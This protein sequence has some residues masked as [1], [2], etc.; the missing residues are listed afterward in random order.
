MTETERS[1]LMVLVCVGAAWRTSGALRNYFLCEMLGT[2]INESALSRVSYTSTL[3]SFLYVVAMLP[4]FLSFFRLSW[5]QSKDYRPLVWSAITSF[6]PFAFAWLLMNNHSSYSW[7]S[8]VEGF[9]YSTGAMALW[10]ET[11]FKFP[12]GLLSFLWLVL[13]FYSY[14]WALWWNVPLWQ[15]LNFSLPAWLVMGSFGWIA[16]NGDKHV[17]KC[18]E[19][20]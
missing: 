8:A 15:H 10:S 18:L 7:I 11:S 14:G 4:V 17:D 3:Y 12:Y 9:L 1:I 20:A 6:I 16:L 5:C 2:I 13:S 19:M